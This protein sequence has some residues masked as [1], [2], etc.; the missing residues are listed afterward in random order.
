[1]HGLGHTWLLLIS[2]ATVQLLEYIQCHCCHSIASREEQTSDQSKASI[3][4]LLL[5]L[6]ILLLLR[7]HHLQCC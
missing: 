7:C 1:M 3:L 6:L 5:L 2:T 4:L